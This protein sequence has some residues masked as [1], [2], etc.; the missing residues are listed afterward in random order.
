MRSLSADGNS[1]TVI[2]RGA[3]AFK[4]FGQNVFPVSSEETPEFMKPGNEELF[5]GADG[6][7]ADNHQRADDTRYL[8]PYWAV[9]I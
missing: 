3:W 6:M 8:R 1:V 2:T 7:G 9:C 5:Y 4:G